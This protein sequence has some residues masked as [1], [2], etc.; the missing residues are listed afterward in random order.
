MAIYFNDRILE[1]LEN[2]NSLEKRYFKELKEVKRVF[3]TF[4]KKGEVKSMLIFER[5]FN[6]V[7]NSRKTTYKPC[8]PIALPMVSNIYVDD[9]GSV[10][11]RYSKDPPIYNNNRLVWRKGSEMFDELRAIS[12][13]EM[14]FAWFILKATNYV[15]KGILK[16]VNK[17]NEFNRDFEKLKIQAR[18]YALLFADERTEEEL[19]NVVADMF[20]E[21][22]IFYEGS[23][24]GE[25][26]LKIWEAVKIADANGSPWGY[27]ELEQTLQKEI[28]KNI[29]RKEKSIKIVKQESGL[30]DEDIP[31]EMV[32]APVGRKKDDLLKEAEEIGLPVNP[33]MTNNLIWS[34]IVAATKQEV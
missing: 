27:V 5:E 1:P 3:D 13:D 19:L 21:N 26:S 34:M 20:P 23:G 18:P 10:Q 33:T 6:K 2:G 12:E 7:W 24:I 9:L 4:R 14:D 15:E 28:D 32:K 29:T 11:V 30:E 16:L 25:L 22:V 17:K 31:V 8:P